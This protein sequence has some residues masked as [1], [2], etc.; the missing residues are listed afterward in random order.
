VKV[1]SAR[2][3]GRRAAPQAPRRLSPE[4]RR[5]EEALRQRLATDVKVTARRRG[6]GQVTVSYYSDDDL[7]RV[8]ELIL[9]KPFQG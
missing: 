3:G 9:G 7:A 5:L 4:H 2:P 1:R 6:R 8:I